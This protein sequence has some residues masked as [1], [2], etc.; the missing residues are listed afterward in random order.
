[1]GRRV[2]RAPYHPANAR[3][4]AAFTQA[5]STPPRSHYAT[6]P[7]NN[8]AQRQRIPAEPLIVALGGGGGGVGRSTVAVELARH[9]ARRGKDV[10]LVDA[11]LHN[12]NL[13]FRLGV[14][15]HELPTQDEPDPEVRP[16]DWTIRTGRNAPALLSLS[17]ACAR[18][19]SSP[20]LDSRGFV[21]Q[22][23][24]TEFELIIIDCAAT[25]DLISTTLFALSDVPIYCASTEP[26][27]VW[28]ATRFARG[29]MLAAMTVTPAGEH[30]RDAIFDCCEQLPCAWSLDDL[31]RLAEVEGCPRS[32]DAVLRTFRPYLLLTQTRE[33]AERELGGP[34]AL[35]WDYLIGLRPRFL[36]SIDY[37][38]RRWF[39][40][41]QDNLTPPLHSLDQGIG[42]Q[43]EELARRITEL[44]EVDAENPRPHAREKHG[45][46]DVF[47][48]SA[49]CDPAHI[50]ATYRRLWE[51]FRRESSVSKHLVSPALR[52][53]ILRDLEDANKD[54]QAW[55]AEKSPRTGPQPIK[56]PPEPTHPGVA[57]QN[58]R[59]GLALS[60]R[61]LS[62][63]TK[64]GLRY[65]E[66]IERFEVEALPRPVYLR[67]YL[68]EVAR[69]LALDPD[70]LLD[71]YLTALSE[72]RAARI[73]RG[74]R[75]LP[76]GDSDPTSE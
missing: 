47:G 19:L 48:V 9:F 39:H 2:I 59:Q 35:A 37:D 68:R 5:P 32:L 21:Q 64:I 13:H 16:D 29:T 74:A 24:S 45:G 49:Q 53:A 34:L 50:R 17:R 71:R 66:A 69:A 76:L 57:I 46:L 10:L 65:L 4:P 27:S 52:A 63:R 36:G 38:E 62:L 25:D 73:L 60:Q 33:S 11:D 28:L 18:P 20:D 67:G 23:R 31:T 41:R 55:L 54:V 44:A 14:P 8:V 12:P 75:T 15:T 42:V 40:L 70:P 43:L 61:E 72:A 51:G 30:E 1:V 3:P 7:L 58:A 6:R 22:L 26:V 56:R